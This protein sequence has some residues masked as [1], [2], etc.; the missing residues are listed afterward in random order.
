[1]NTN[2]ILII[3][4]AKSYDFGGGERVPVLIARE[5]ENNSDLWPIVLSGSQKLLD[6]AMKESVSHM[7]SWWW[8]NQNWSGP[9]VLLTPIYIVWQIIL[10]FYYLIV[11]L[12]FRPSAV[13]LQSKDDFIAG[14]FAAR[15]LNIRVLWSDYA[16][17]KHI[18]MNH[19][20]WYKNPIGKMVYI[21]A[22]FT[23]KIIVVSEEDKSLISV[24]IPNGTVKNKMI[25]I[26][27]GAFDI[28]KKTKKSEVFTFTSSSRI[29]TDKGMCELIEAF[30]MLNKEFP[31]TALNII[32]DGPERNHF[33][34]LAKSNKS[35]SFLGYKSNALD[36]VNKAHVF[37]I[38]TYHEGFS[39]ALV[40]ACM[41]K[42]P[43]IATAVGGNVEI[44]YDH[45]TGLLVP[46]K[47]VNALYE[48]MKLLYKDDKLRQKLADNAR[49]QY[50][51]NFQ[52]CQI[53]KEKFI[54]I[55]E[56]KKK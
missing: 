48:A 24:H 34:K 54:P 26:Y 31:N 33:E 23:E 28:Y 56:G 35:I 5:V 8:S 43:I 2:R 37:I 46:V 30:E 10:Y 9:R 3:R 18:F 50:L 20:V 42:M 11:F 21:A 55:Y 25:V 12:K 19:R 16:D 44:I 7:K 53:V 1:M 47:N 27:N 39:L 4:N 17:L 40:E 29:V 13:H 51:K 6:F 15:T 45:Q 38:A 22:H 52:F 14:T 41:M 32:G 36:Y 49:E